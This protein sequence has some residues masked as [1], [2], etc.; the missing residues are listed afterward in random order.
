MPDNSGTFAS[1]PDSHG[2]A[3]SDLPVGAVVEVITKNRKYVLENRGLGRFL[4]SGH[5]DYCPQPVLVEL[6]G[7]AMPGGAVR[8][9]Y[10]GR[11]MC[12]EF[13]HPMRG[14]IHTSRIEDIRTVSPAPA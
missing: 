3:A 7:S 14:V 8:L 9:N 6:F 12:L 2:I 5:P 4:I 13:R 1:M 11:G 10:I